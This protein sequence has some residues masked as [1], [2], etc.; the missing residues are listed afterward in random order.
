MIWAAFVLIGL[1]FI[2]QQP[3][4]LRALMGLLLLGL[5][6]LQMLA[7]GRLPLGPA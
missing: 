4:W 7:T 6:A 5:V 1:A 3:A 2:Q